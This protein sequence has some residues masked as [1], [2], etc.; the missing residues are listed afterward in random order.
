MLTTTEEHWDTE[1][2]KL[3]AEKEQHVA[4][5]RALES[6]SDIERKRKRDVEDRITGFQTKH[7]HPLLM[8]LQHVFTSSLIVL[9]QEYLNATVCSECNETIYLMSLHFV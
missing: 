7:K 2:Q 3:I 4:V 9:C 6:Q 1:L 5:L 8:Y